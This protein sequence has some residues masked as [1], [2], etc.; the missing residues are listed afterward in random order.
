MQHVD[1]GVPVQSVLGRCCV[2]FAPAPAGTAVPL[3]VRVEH[4]MRHFFAEFFRTGAKR[5]LGFMRRIDL[6]TKSW[7]RNSWRVNR[8]SAGGARE[9]HGRRSASA[10]LHVRQA[11]RP[12]RGVPAK[13]RRAP[14]RHLAY[15]ARRRRRL[16]LCGTHG[17]S[18]TRLSR[19]EWH[20]NSDAYASHQA[21]R[22]PSL[23]VQ[24]LAQPSGFA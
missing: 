19:P 4:V 3:Q 21:T 17:E 16:A 9:A 6:S 2:D 11:V 5:K 20:D 15:S 18:S 12:P 22:K 7:L 24:Q 23:K 14:A 10:V 1:E 13:A 8:V